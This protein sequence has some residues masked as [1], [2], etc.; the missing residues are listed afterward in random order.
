MKMLRA[1]LSGLVAF[2]AVAIMAVAISYVRCLAAGISYNFSIAL[3]IAM[4]AGLIPGIAIF[5]L[6]LA[7]LR[8]RPPP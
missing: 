7:G 5:T 8:R 1:G 4:K 2:V 3:P 6:T